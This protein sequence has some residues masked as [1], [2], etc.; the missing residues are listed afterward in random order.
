MRW[1]WGIRVHMRCQEYQMLVVPYETYGIQSGIGK[2]LE[3]RT[4]N[5]LGRGK[6]TGGG[7]ACKV[8]RSMS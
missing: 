1:N 3:L 2:G 4:G 8:R 7:T 6:V 5:T